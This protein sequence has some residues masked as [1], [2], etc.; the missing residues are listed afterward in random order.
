MKLSLFL[1]IFSEINFD[2][3]NI[4]LSISFY[5]NIILFQYFQRQL[6][7]NSQKPFDIIFI[8][9]FQRIVN[10]TFSNFFF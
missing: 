4:F 10:D 5:K 7:N 3:I 1:K 2:L 6:I 9:I 8:V